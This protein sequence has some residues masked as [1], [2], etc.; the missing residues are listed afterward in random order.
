[1][2]GLRLN[3]GCAMRRG[4]FVNVDKFGEP[5]LRHDLETFP[6]PWPDDSVVEVVLHHVLEHLGHDPNV[7]LGIMKEMD[8]VCQDSATIRIEEIYMTRRSVSRRS[9]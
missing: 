8:R 9:T 4:G 6:W 1:M 2:S 5:E 7:D 3:L